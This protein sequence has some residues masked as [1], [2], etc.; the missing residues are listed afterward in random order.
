MI[1]GRGLIAFDK[2]DHSG[3]YGLPANITT[4]GPMIIHMGKVPPGTSDEFAFNEE[5]LVKITEKFI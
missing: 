3:Q 5:G 4:K 1:W 2:D